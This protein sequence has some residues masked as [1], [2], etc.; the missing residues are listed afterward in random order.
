MQRVNDLLARPIVREFSK[1]MMATKRLRNKLENRVMNRLGY[2]QGAVPDIRVEKALA[3]L[4]ATLLDKARPVAVFRLL[5]VVAVGHDEILTQE[6]LI[7][8]QKFSWLLSV[9]G[10]KRYILCE[11]ITLGIELDNYFEKARLYLRAI[12]DALGSEMVE[13]LA[14]VAEEEM[15]GALLKSGLEKS[16]R[17]SPGYCDMG[18]KNQEVIFTVLD[19]GLQQINASLDPMFI[20]RPL[21]SISGFEAVAERVPVAGPCAFCGDKDCRYRR[22]KRKGFEVR[23]SQLAEKT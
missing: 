20:M 11:F 8:S 16:M 3:E 19:K 17:F 7:T 21:K 6:G 9:C 10:G 14:D 4:F 23:F 13:M 15:G 22:V 18:L 1:G 2:A 12:A 5:E